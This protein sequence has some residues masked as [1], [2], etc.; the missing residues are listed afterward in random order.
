LGPA[1]YRA[2]RFKD[3]VAQLHEVLVEGRPGGPAAAAFDWLWLAMAQERR[4]QPAKARQH[5][6]HFEQLAREF[7]ASAPTV[8]R[9]VTLSWEDWLEY[10]FLRAEAAELINPEQVHRDRARDFTQQRE[11]DKAA[12]AL[13]QAIARQPGDPELY[14]E[15]GRDYARLSQWAKARADY[16]KAVASRPVHDDWFELACLH[17]IT[18]DQRAYR[19]MAA[20]MARDFG[21]TKD[22]FTAYVAARIAALTPNS[23]VDPALAVRWA[24]Q[25]VADSPKAWYLHCLGLAYYRAGQ[26]EAAIRQFEASLKAQVNWS[27][28]ML[29]WLGLALSHHALGH[30]KEARRWLAMATAWLD[31]ATK[32]KEGPASIMP[33]PDWLEYQV[34]RHEAETRLKDKPVGPKKK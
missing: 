33:P 2:G 7:G 4:E 29:N 21:Q 23:G 25:A 14:L 11:W 30:T 5:L 18:G 3:A 15:R 13:T 8:Q 20:R 24:N 1:Y 9:A 10:G 22:V 6:A 19:R 26:T 17:L 31:Q 27:G 32:G 34:L 12:D 28:K 16:A